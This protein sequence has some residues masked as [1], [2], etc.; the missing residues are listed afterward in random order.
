M[1]MIT[2]ISLVSLAISGAGEIRTLA[3]QKLIYSH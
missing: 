1:Q 2:R 3:P